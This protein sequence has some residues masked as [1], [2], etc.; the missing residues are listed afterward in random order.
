MNKAT[1]LKHIY[2]L[3][4]Y[5]KSLNIQVKHSSNSFKYD[6]QTHSIT[7]DVKLK[8]NPYKY[9]C[10]YL[11]ELGHAVQDISLFNTL[12]KSKAVYITIMIEQEHDAWYQGKHIAMSLGIW[13]DIQDIYMSEWSINWYGYIKTLPKLKVK[14]IKTLSSGYTI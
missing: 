9:L 2:T 14:D 3:N 7:C 13:E 4:Q 10:G 6:P 11:H 1:Y 5:A 8:A 12:H